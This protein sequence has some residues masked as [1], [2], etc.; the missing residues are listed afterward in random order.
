MRCRA[1]EECMAEHP[2]FSVEETT[3]LVN[4]RL[5]PD[6]VT[7]SGAQ[8]RLLSPLEIYFSQ[9]HVR[10]EFQDGRSLEG[11]IAAIGTDRCSPLESG[12]SCA[13][14]A[15]PVQD[16]GVPVGSDSWWLLTPPFIEIEV[17]LWRCK[18]REEDGSTKVDAAGNELYGERDWYTLDNRRL[19]CLQK[20]AVSLYPAEVRVV[21][22]VVTQDQGNCREFRKFRTLDLGRSVGV[23]HRDETDMPRWLWR[24]EVNLPAEP[25]PVGTPSGRPSGRRQRRIS[26]VNGGQRQGPGSR[27]DD[28]DVEEENGGGRDALMNVMFFVMVYALLRLA[29]YSARRVFGLETLF[30]SWRSGTASVGAAEMGDVATPGSAE[31]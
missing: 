11:A 7:S 13:A 12:G 16:L 17:I 20:A 29:L 15:V 5:G 1:T 2:T 6:G 27:R 14:D 24:K 30:G 31:L 3:K 26:S 4:D 19:Y 9:S 10:P 8:L 23:G 21:V 25:L 22:S 18:M 28:D